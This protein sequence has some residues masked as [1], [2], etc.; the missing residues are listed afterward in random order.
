MNLSLRHR[1]R[2]L[3]GENEIFQKFR[4]PHSGNT[5]WVYVCVCVCMCVH[6]CVCVCVC[7]FVCG[8]SIH[9][10]I[11]MFVCVCARVCVHGYA[12]VGLEITPLLEWYRN[13]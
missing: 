10:Y 13:T 12:F 7:V 8:M 6:V 1:R 5:I 9:I 4:K 3:R 2:R 11:Y